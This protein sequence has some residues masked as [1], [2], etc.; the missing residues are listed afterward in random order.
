MSNII[1]IKPLTRVE[2]H[3]GVRVYM[4]GSHVD[5]VELAW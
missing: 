3:G 1:E 2:G 5:R 4:D